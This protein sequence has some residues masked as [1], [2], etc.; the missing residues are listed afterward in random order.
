MTKFRKASVSNQERALQSID[1]HMAIYNAL[2]SHDPE[3]AEQAAML[4]VRNAMRR[5]E[6]MEPNE[7][8]GE[9]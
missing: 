3:A 9:P 4:H 1:E 6:L 5:M 7:P 2:A 8:A